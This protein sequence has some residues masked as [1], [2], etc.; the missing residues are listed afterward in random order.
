MGKAPF[1]ACKV[2]SK[3]TSPIITYDPM[4]FAIICLEPTNTPIAIGRSYADPSFLM[5][6]GDMFT[7]TLNPGHLKPWLYM[8]T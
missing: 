4:F 8:A 5:S 1:M 6:A 7:T 2:P 3:E